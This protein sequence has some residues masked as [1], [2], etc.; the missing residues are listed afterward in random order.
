MKISTKLT[1][2]A[3]AGALCLAM[4]TMAFAAPSAT[5][6]DTTETVVTV[7]VGGNSQNVVADNSQ[8][9]VPG[10]GK[11]ATN[12]YL[13]GETINGKSATVTITAPKANT[14]YTVYIQ[15]ADGKVTHVSRQ[16]NDNKQITF[17]IAK[18]PA[19]ISLVAGNNG[20]S[21]A[22]KAG[23]GT[24]PQTGMDLTAPIAG[25]VITLATAAGAAFV[26]RKKIAE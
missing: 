24:S 23:N 4:P 16:S 9:T 10:A 19:N 15:D 11:D 17:T 22:T 2:A 6:T 13:G 21:D 12:F 25:G 18:F 20:N 3:V 5:A 14:W 26:L 8:F 7:N 1:S